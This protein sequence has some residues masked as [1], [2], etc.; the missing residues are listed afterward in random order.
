MAENEQAQ[1]IAALTQR[2]QEFG[3]NDEEDVCFA[4]VEVGGDKGGDEPPVQTW[5]VVGRFLTA[6]LIKLEYMRQVLA[7]VW[8]PVMGVT[9]T[10]INKGLFLF[11]FFH[12]TDVDYVLNGG[13][14]AFENST[15]VCRMVEDGVLPVDVELN[16]VDMWVQLHDVPMGYT[17]LPML[18]QMGNFIGTFVKHDE[19]FVGAP[20]LAF[21]RI[22]VSIPLDKPLRRR[23]K[24]LKRDKTTC[25]IN[26]RYERLHSFCFFCGLLGHTYKFCVKARVSTVP[27]HLYPYNAELRVGGG[28]GPREVGESWLVPVEGRPRVAE[29]VRDEGGRK[30]GVVGEGMARPVV[31]DE[32]EEPVEVVSKRRREGGYEGERRG[33]GQD[34]TM[35]DVS[36]NLFMAGAGSQTRP[37]S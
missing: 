1:H 6:R 7:S 17:S 30:G 4:P 15:L 27:V 5:S 14:W 33:D 8:Q 9:V 32:A 19:R 34:T 25:W 28:R 20:W 24:L 22:R 29:G 36:K 37:A 26:F 21:Y 11:I 3:I 2:T 12:K 13:P 23:M 10:E 18:E 16:T 31:V 35:A